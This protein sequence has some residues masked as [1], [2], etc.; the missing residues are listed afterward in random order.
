MP[1]QGAMHA[2]CVTLSWILSLKRISLGQQVKAE[3]G[4]G[5]MAAVYQHYLSSF[6]GCTVGE[7][8]RAML[9]FLEIHTKAF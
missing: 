6:S 3:R 7:L 2:R 4:E 1:R 8:C 5:W 9:R